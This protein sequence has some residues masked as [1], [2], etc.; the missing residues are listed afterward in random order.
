MF[1]PQILR[2]IGIKLIL[3]S[4]ILLIKSK[5]TKFN[6]MIVMATT[7]DGVYDVDKDV[8]STVLSYNNYRVID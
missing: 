7:K 2:V 8:V 4:L 3:T 6:K 5:E 1:I